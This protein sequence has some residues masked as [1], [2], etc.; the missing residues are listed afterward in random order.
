MDA[1][2]HRNWGCHHQKVVSIDD[3]LA[4]VGGIDLCL[5]RW[6]TREH[7][8]E[9]PR[10]ADH[11]RRPYG[12]FHDT[13]AV[14]SGEAARWVA[15]MSRE[16]WKS[17]TGET[18]PE[19]IA[20]ACWPE[21]APVDFQNVELGIARTLWSERIDPSIREVEELYLDCI[22]SAEKYVYIENQYLT[23]SRITDAI[24]SRLKEQN[25]P[26]FVVLVPRL[27]SGWKEQSTMGLL[28]ARRLEKLRA[29]NH[30]GKLRILSP[31][32]GTS[33]EVPVNLHSK[34]MIID[35]RIFQV[36]S[37]NLSNRSLSLDT[38]CNVAIVADGSP[39]TA[40]SVSL[41]IARLRARLLAEHI[42]MTEDWVLEKTKTTG[43]LLA[44]LDAASPKSQHRL[45]PMDDRLSPMV[46]LILPENHFIDPEEP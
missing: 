29:C 42:G 3:Q 7:K 17:A 5:K 37:A 21:E 39:E 44:V 38:E 33:L 26:E 22:A 13:Q 32:V 40:H 14:F 27:N 23:S 6:D 16:R 12:P 19:V 18:L 41:G 8:L 25:C 11:R 24:C 31:V 28:R 15:R 2:H 20:S 9:D 34:V 46:D 43:S 45:I 36:G 35:D 4:F 10:R 30:Q 1:N